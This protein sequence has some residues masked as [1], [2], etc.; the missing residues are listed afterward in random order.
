MSELFTS[1]NP[2][3]ALTVTSQPSTLS[4]TP[5]SQTN[6]DDHPLVF[7]R[8]GKGFVGFGELIRAE[9][10]GPGRFTQARAWWNELVARAT[11]A[12]GVNRPGSGLMVFGAFTFAD[13]S[14]QTS[15]FIVPERV[16]GVDDA[17]TFETVITGENLL[18]DAPPTGPSGASAPSRGWE[19]GSVTEEVFL[20]LVGR[21]KQAISDHGL[22]KVVI[23]RDLVT[24]VGSSF[25]PRPVLDHLAESYPDTYVFCVDGLFGA[26]PETL[27]SVRGKSITLRVLAGSAARGT[28]PE[29]DRSAAEALATSTK[30]LDEHQFAVR[31]VVESLAAGGIDAIADDMP[32][33]LK[34]P[35]LWHLATDVVA[36]VP[37]GAGA[38]DVVGA[39]HPTAA[40]AGSPTDAALAFL[41][42]HEPLDRGRYAGPVGWMDSRGDGDWAIALRCAQHDTQA[43]LLTAYA[44]AGI[45]AD[46]EADQEL[47]ET[48]LKFRPIIDALLPP[49]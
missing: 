42:S 22:H 39:L 21:A 37:G 14:A 1:D 26:S 5:L 48:R 8:R 29:E 13:V 46:S 27:A 9:F 28:H 24:D 11:V 23:A 20:E 31:N 4:G 15:V 32:F 10:S 25:S 6:P 43:N 7:Q 36:H 19:E 12:D 34:L 38:L 18:S 33:T 16:I 3:P 49:S 44:G 41:E 2:V 40:V 17:G 30:D 45:V 35:N 47:L